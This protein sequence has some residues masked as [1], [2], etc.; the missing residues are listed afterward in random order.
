M[1]VV[2]CTKIQLIA[3]I[4]YICTEIFQWVGVSVLRKASFG[5][6]AMPATTNT[7]VHN[8]ILYVQLYL[9]IYFQKQ[10]IWVKE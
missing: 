10:D 8:V 7:L 1:Q 2:H 3:Q 6:L 5:L 9:R 4:L